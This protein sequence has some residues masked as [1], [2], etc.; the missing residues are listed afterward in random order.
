MEQT[1]FDWLLSLINE[2][3]KFGSWL[4][5]PLP[6]INLPPLAVFGFGGLTILIGIHLVRL[7]VGG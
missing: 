3:S 5:M 7:F 1:L 6:Y 2:F 4:T